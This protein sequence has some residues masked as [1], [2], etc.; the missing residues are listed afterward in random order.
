M[1]RLITSSDVAKRLGVSNHVVQSLCRNGMLFGAVKQGNRWVIPEESVEKYLE[2][3][4]S[5]NDN[6]IISK[7]RGFISQILKLLNQ[8]KKQPIY[9]LLAEIIGVILVIVTLA[10]GIIGFGADFNGAIL[11]AKEFGILNSLEFPSEQKDEFL[12]VV[13]SFYTTEGIKN[14]DIEGEI[15]RSIKKEADNLSI[16]NI[17]VEVESAK[18]KSFDNDSAERLGIKYNASIV[19]WGENTGVRIDTNFLIIKNNYFPTN[20]VIEEI[21]NVET[22]GDDKLRKFVTKNLPDRIQFLSLFAVGQY[23]YKEN[24]FP[25][26]V[27]II[28]RGIETL[29]EDNNVELSEVELE[30]IGEAYYGIAFMNQKMGKNDKETLRYFDNS[31]EYNPKKVDAYINRGVLK[32]VL[33]DK[34]GAV[35]DFKKAVELNDNNSLSHYN[36]AVMLTNEGNFEFSLKEYN[37]CLE[38]EPKNAKYLNNRGYLLNIMQKYD[39]A[40]NDLELAISIDPKNPFPYNNLGISLRNLNDPQGALTNF[41]KAVQ[42][43][44]NYD[45]ALSNLA[46]QLADMG[47]PE[48]GLTYINRAIDLKPNDIGYHINRAGILDALGDVEG[49]INDYNT[50]VSLDPSNPFSYFARGRYFDLKGDPLKSKGDLNTVI[51]LCN[52]RN[53]YNC[54]KL[55][56]DAENELDTIDN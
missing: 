36:L 53:D 39:I 27:K 2:S 4:R 31:I 29:K 38:I 14:V 26:A 19:I 47:K 54:N 10:N 21:D 8:L 3:I 52:S 7:G 23:Y 42:L 43:R 41:E 11:K 9:I 55:L 40:K 28:S 20:A 46:S 50:A 15:K 6:F 33:H 37:K 30:S 16:R 51:E 32:A 34:I 13:A 17:R 44:D 18:L 1:D 12:I 5:A 35:D 48:S 49:S 56:K 24:N 22:A 45:I 25:D